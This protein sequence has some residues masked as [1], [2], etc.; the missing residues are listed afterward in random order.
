MH[1]S[2]TIHL[3]LPA[4]YDFLHLLHPSIAALLSVFPGFTRK[5]GRLYNIHLAVHEACANIIEHAYAGQAA[6]RIALAITL[7]KGQHRLMVELRDT[8]RSFNIEQVPEPDLESLQEGG[9]GLFLMR[10]LMDEVIY[11]P[12]VDGNYWQLVKHLV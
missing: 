7:H 8:G 6:G 2:E 11:Q 4:S 10:S 12:G 9:Y 5:D 3:N 1:D